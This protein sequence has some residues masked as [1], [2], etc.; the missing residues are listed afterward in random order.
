MFVISFHIMSEKEV[1]CYLFYQGQCFRF[2]GED[3][4]NVMPIFFVDSDRAKDI[5]LKKYNH[6][7]K[8]RK[9]FDEFCTTFI[10]TTFDK[11]YEGLTNQSPR[12]NV[13]NNY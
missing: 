10:D 9:A 13:M 4:I 11:F 2:F 3:L 6:E 5:M 8:W 12:I 7:E 1:R